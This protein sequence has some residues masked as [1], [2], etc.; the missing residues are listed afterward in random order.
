[1]PSCWCQC[2]A[3]CLFQ[4]ALWR[5]HFLW[6]WYCDKKQIEMWFTVVCTLINNEC[7]SSLFPKHFFVLFL[8]VQGVCKPI[9]VLPVQQLMGHFRVTLWLRTSLRAKPL[10]WTWVWFEWKWTS[11]GTQFQMNGF[12]RRLVLTHIEAKR[13]AERKFIFQ[14]KWFYLPCDVTRPSTWVAGVSVIRDI[15]IDKCGPRS[16]LCSILG[17]WREFSLPLHP[18]FPIF[19]IL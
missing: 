19:C 5:K 14:N 2:V 4:V 3:Q 18:I 11:R 15:D 1:M 6:R 16:H 10:V 9:T 13:N 7:A 12:A 8:H 17:K